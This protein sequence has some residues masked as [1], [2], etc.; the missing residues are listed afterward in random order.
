MNSSAMKERNGYRCAFCLALHDSQLKFD[1]LGRCVDCVP[2]P[3]LE[4]WQAAIDREKRHEAAKKRIRLAA[5]KLEGI[6]VEVAKLV[7]EG[8]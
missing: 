6:E 5:R 2:V 4:H 8:S 3:F 7:E 1:D